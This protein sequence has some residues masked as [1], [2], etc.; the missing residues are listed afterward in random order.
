MLRRAWLFS[1]LL[2]LSSTSLQAQKRAFTIEDLYRVK[3]ISDLHISPDGKNVIFAVATSDLARAKRTTHI[4]VMNT[5]GKNL[6]QLT[7]GDGSETSPSFSPDGKQILFV[8]SKD[9]IDNLYLMPFNLPS[10][11]AP[12]RKL[13]NLSTS[14]Y[15]PLW[16]P[17][18]KWIAFSS[19]VYP[20]CNGDDACN[21]KTGERWSSGALQAHMADELL[22]RH[23]TSWKDG[24]RTHTFIANAAT[25]A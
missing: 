13:T 10:G 17:D 9:G 18:G 4:W 14:V 15:D 7:T 6:R 5:D 21:K 12:W 16:S 1:V 2:L 23:W 19:D 20:E 25:G 11:K 3:N 22:Y 24:T 8:S